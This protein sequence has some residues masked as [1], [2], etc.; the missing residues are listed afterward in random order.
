MQAKDVMTTN[1]ISVDVETTIRE[2]CRLLLEKGITGLPVVNQ[3]GQLVGMITEFGLMEA[4]YNPSIRNDPIRKYM[5]RDV[6]TVDENEP[7]AHVASLFLLHRIRRLPVVRN[8]DMDGRV[9]GI[10]SR[11]DLMRIVVDSKEEITPVPPLSKTRPMFA[12]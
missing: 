9:V 11:R 1:V 3:E 8:A 7:I 10:I 12:P 5:T 2:A 6:L 4:L